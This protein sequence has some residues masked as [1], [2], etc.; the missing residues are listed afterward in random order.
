MVG[1]FLLMLALVP[2]GMC[3]TTS[4][5]EVVAS[6]DNTIQCAVTLSEYLPK[7]VYRKEINGSYSWHRMPVASFV[8]VSP[9]KFVERN[10]RIAFVSSRY[11]HLKSEFRQGEC[12]RF[13][14]RLPKDYFN[15]ADGTTIESYQVESISPLN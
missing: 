14:L 5:A 4:V 15:D 10:I 3:Q 13:V 6:D 9:I 12:G 8:V 7:H 11:D 1:A 2:V